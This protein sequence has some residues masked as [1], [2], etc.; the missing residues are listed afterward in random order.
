[1]TALLEPTILPAQR[2]G[3]IGRLAA[4]CRRSLPPLT[5][6]LVGTIGW[7]LVVTSGA[8]AGILMRGWE[9]PGS[10]AAVAIVYA[11]GAAIA[12]PVALFLARFVS[13]RRSAEAAFA[14]MFLAL[15]LSTVGITAL[16][17]A[18]NYRMYYAAWHEDF[19]TITW[20]FQLVFTT[21]AAVIQ[22]AV[23]GVRLFFPAGFIALFVASLWFA[24]RAR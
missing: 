7:T 3:L 24:R 19:G 11:V 2:P 23:L 18:L 15:A 8:A 10:I 9:T 5:V 20:I 21:A 17:F 13:Y 12:F 16:V 14:A 6:T 1:V 22:F 4:H